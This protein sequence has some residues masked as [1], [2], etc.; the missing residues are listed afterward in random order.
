MQIGLFAQIADKDIDTP[1]HID[2]NLEDIALDA[3]HKSNSIQTLKERLLLYEPSIDCA[4][5][6]ETDKGID[7]ILKN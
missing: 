7:I 1:T 4:D 3:R 6:H 2:L 5:I